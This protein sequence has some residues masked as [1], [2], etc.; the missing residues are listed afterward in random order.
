M[1]PK[2]LLELIDKYNEKGVFITSNGYDVYWFN[3]IRF[4][5]WCTSQKRI[6]LIFIFKDNLY[7]SNDGQ[8]PKQKYK[9]LKLIPLESIKT[10]IPYEFHFDRVQ[11]SNGKVW[12]SNGYYLWEYYSAQEVVKGGPPFHNFIIGYGNCIHLFGNGVQNFHQIYDTT[13]SKF[14]K[15]QKE[16]K[17]L[18]DVV[19]FDDIVVLD[20]FFYVF[21]A[22][23]PVIIY[24][25]E[26]ETWIKT[27][28]TVFRN[29]D[30]KSAI[31]F[32]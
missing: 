7:L 10:R 11:L 24:D 26:N 8:C 6:D 2:V 15:P 9:N 21:K 31:R 28:T 14:L 12:V 16:S 23:W 20:K 17:I 4:E 30:T 25:I 19:P 32:N 27:T 29:D 22:N 3:G 1:I 13:T 5:Y 18:S